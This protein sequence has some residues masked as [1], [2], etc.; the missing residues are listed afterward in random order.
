[1]VKLGS[2]LM[3]ALLAVPIVRDCCLPVVHTPQCHESKRTDDITC[4]ANDQAIAE[5]KA[6]IGSNSTLDCAFRVNED[7]H[8][9]V[10]NQILSAPDGVTPTTIPT[11]D[12]YLRTGALLI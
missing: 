9:A 10:L 6:A 5:T 3:I 12:L 8:S 7:V 2:L 1:M 4:S 11:P